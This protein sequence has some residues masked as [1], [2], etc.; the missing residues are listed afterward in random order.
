VLSSVREFFLL[1]KA[2]A[3]ANEPAA[4]EPS[5]A[6]AVA[7]R[8]RAAEELVGPSTN[9]AALVL[10][11]DALRFVRDVD[12]ITSSL[13]APRLRDALR[14]LRSEDPLAFD[15]LSS[16]ELASL[17]ENVSDLFAWL[18]GT[19]RPRS[20]REIRTMRALR[21]VGAALAI[22]LVGR[23]TLRAI[24]VPHNQA[25]HKPVFASSRYEGTPEPAGL[26]DGDRR[27]LGVHTLVENDPWVRID[28]ASTYKVKTIRVY[29]RTECCGDEILPLIV[30]VGEEN[31]PA[32][33]VA[34]RTE[35]F[36]VW[37]IDVGGHPSSSV[38]L[39]S[40]RKGYIALAEVEVL[41]AP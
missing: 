28:L 2:Q 25:L 3:L 26:T 27:K 37:E 8:R 16:S 33:F 14:A 4:V 10:Y 29:N 34:E 39:H 1:E 18:D 12:A 5:H 24:L 9:I 6:D 23:M 41:G 31:D 13:E 7:R 36:E 30:E 20:V 15:R 17:R 22:F 35:T 40:R 21:L 32:P 19:L 38:K 11:R